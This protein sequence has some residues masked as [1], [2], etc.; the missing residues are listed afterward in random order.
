MGLQD[1]LRKA[2]SLLVELPPET[3]E[4]A[5]QDAT[6]EN[7]PVRDG[8]EEIDINALLAQQ[9][10]GPEARDDKTMRRK[11]PSGPAPGG[12]K[13]VEQIVR[14]AD[15]PNLDEI[16]VADTAP[17]ASAGGIDCAAI[18]QAA[19]LP[20]APFVTDSRRA[21]RSAMFSPMVAIMWVSSSLTVRPLPG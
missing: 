19:K 12:A 6:G 20:P 11:S 8:R 21:R 17:A 4:P 10:I 7:V 9:G 1:A 18:Y 3:S 5:V 2:A 15:G 13:T 14:D 16:K